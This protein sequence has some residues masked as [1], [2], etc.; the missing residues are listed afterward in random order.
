[1]QPE[2]AP[3]RWT[4][5]RRRRAVRR[6]RAYAYSYK[7]S[8]SLVYIIYALHENGDGLLDSCC[9]LYRISFFFFF[10]W[11]GGG[12]CRYRSWKAE[13]KKKMEDVEKPWI[14][15]RPVA[16]AY[17]GLIWICLTPMKSLTKTSC[18]WKP[19]LWSSYFLEQKWTYT[20]QS[21]CL[22]KPISVKKRTCI[23]LWFFDQQQQ[24][25]CLKDMYARTVWLVEAGGRWI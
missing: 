24:L 23:V 10:F 2:Y 19:V 6:C 7:L 18:G 17:N 25:V 13:E 8:V 4:V 5:R 11:G 1:M 20:K 15:Q 9:N 3:R 16:G 21:T 14:L 12:C 22:R